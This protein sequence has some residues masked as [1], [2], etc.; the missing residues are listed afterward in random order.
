MWFI[1]CLTA[2]LLSLTSLQQGEQL[3]LENK[4]REALP[5]LER[6]LYE[7]PQEEK[8]Y[9]YLGIVYEQL[10]DAEKSIQILKRGLNVSQGYKDLFYYN[11]G[12]NHFRRQEFTVAEQMYSNALQINGA[13]EVAYLN[14][15]NAR[16]ELEEFQEAR[17]DY[18]DYLQLD[19]DTH[20]R[21]NIEKL[22]ALLEQL[23]EEA[24]RERLEELERQKALLN[25][26][27]DTLKNASEDTRNLSAGSEEIQEEYEEIDIEN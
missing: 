22:I 26:V 16:L 20:Q 18:I 24:E 25:E 19:P 27:L 14:R 7:N 12:N 13:L 11:L 21:E 2:V 9:L 1:S 5:H 8:I 4:P 10:G 23:I 3:F 6:A 15:A 17:Q